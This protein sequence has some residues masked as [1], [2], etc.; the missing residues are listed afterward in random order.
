MDNPGQAKVEANPN[1]TD[2][3][4]VSDES[5]DDF[6]EINRSFLGMSKFGPKI[7]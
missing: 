5:F 4:V 1:Q 2:D 6:N 7:G 3:R